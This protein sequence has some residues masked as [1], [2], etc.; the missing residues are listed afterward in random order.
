MKKSEL[1]QKRE[2]KIH[3]LLDDILNFIHFIS[4]IQIQ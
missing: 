4:V 2:R 3:S 1:S